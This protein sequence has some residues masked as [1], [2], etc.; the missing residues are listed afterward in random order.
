MESV[1]VTEEFEGETV[2]DSTVEVYDLI[3]HPAA[4]NV[5]REGGRNGRRHYSISGGA[6]R[7]ACGLT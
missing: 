3:D 2:R 6:T 7:A 1:R 4:T 5:I